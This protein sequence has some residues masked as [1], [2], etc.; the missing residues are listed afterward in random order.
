M[1]SLELHNV[2]VHDY[3]YINS[4]CILYYMY[5]G[6]SLMDTLYK[7]HNSNNLRTDLMVTNEELHILTIHFEPLKR[8]QTSTCMHVYKG[9]VPRCP[10]YH[11]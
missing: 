11:L 8:G 4:G 3:M 1:Y 10:L 2:H 7:G 9:L 5:S 6:T